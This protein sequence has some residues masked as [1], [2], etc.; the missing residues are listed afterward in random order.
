MVGG[1]FTQQKMQ[2]NQLN[3]QKELADKAQQNQLKIAE[4]RPK[5]LSQPTGRPSGTTENNQLKN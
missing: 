5:T 4:M 3:V 2:D 1:Q